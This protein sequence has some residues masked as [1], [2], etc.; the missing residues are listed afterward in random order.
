MND[1]EHDDEHDAWQLHHHGASWED[2]GIEMGCSPTTAQTLAAAYEK[3][4]DTAAHDAQN[5][6]F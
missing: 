6:L 3:R 4:T 1:D 5:A 2:I